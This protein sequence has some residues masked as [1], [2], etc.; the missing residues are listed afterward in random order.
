[1]KQQNNYM[2]LIRNL[3]STIMTKS[4]EKNLHLWGFFFSIH[5]CPT[6]PLPHRQRW[7]RISRICSEFQQCGG[8]RERELRAIV[9]KDALFFEGTKKLQ[10][11]CEYCIDAQDCTM[12]VHNPQTRSNGPE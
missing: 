6:P 11:I 7:A 5:T 8:W 10:K 2:Y 1:M 3:K 9:K 4:L 12:Q